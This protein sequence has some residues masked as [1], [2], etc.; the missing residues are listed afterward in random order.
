MR[1]REMRTI[2][3]FGASRL[4]DGVVCGQRVFDDYDQAIG[5]ISR[6]QKRSPAM[7][8]RS[9]EEIGDYT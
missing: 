8:I 6:K 2:V 3:K 5:W 4:Q 7:E 1:C 9:I